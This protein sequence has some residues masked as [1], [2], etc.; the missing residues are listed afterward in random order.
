MRG[1]VKP[2][3]QP[4]W[5]TPVPDT[6][7]HRLLQRI[8]A[9]LDLSEAVRLAEPYFADRGRPSVPVEQMIKAMLV[10][11]LLG[12]TTD[13]QLVEVCAD[14]L[15]CREFLGLAYDDRMF[16][17]ANFTQWRQRLG[18][19]YFRTVL[20][21]VVRQCQA[22]GM[23]LGPA[24]TVDASTIKAQ[25]DRQGPVVS[26]PRETDVDQYLQEAFAAD[27]PALPGA[28]NNLPINLHDP[29]ARLQRKGAQRAEFAYQGSFS[30]DPDSGLITDATATPT[31]QPPTMVAHVDHDPGL[32]TE[33]VADSRYD[34]GVS[35]EQLQDRGVTPYVPQASRTRA[36]QINKDQFVYEPEHDRYCCPNGCYL[37]FFNVEPRERRRRYRA[38]QSDCASCPFKNQCTRG[39]RRYIDRHFAATAREQTVRA[40]PRYRQL[41][42][43]RRIAEH[44][45]H[46][47]K[48]DHGM[49][50]ARGLG[51]AAARIQVALTAM[52]I[53]LK[54][55]VRFTTAPRQA[56][57]AVAAA[58]R[59][60]WH[61]PRAPRVGP[62][63]H[64]AA[65]PSARALSINYFT[66]AA[67]LAF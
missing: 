56:V 3:Q 24:R 27:E 57:R 22:H 49:R 19:D 48:R 15:A 45:F 12:I 47:A 1:K 14:S 9:L 28:D 6:S 51:L 60:R 29:D 2:V 4:L 63:P 16:V 65:D 44:L 8:G 67:R 37:E 59:G 11:C 55:L 41:M 26:L 52:A 54:K 21:D 34:D 58:L 23:R 31:E 5:A 35:L 40:G 7:R 36:G 13:R 33:L 43:E 18:P 62:R 20:H 25:A 42:R 32:V 46:L 17:H 61:D 50:R 39:T 64:R 66:T 53:D 10:G 38:H 30:A